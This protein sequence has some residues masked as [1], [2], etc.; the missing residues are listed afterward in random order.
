[1]EDINTRAFELS[2]RIL[3]VTSGLDLP[4]GNWE[5][6]VAGVFLNQANT[7]LSSIMTLLSEN[8]LESAIILCRSLFELAVDAVYIYRDPDKLDKRV[9]Q[10]LDCAGIPRTPEATKELQLEIRENPHPELDEII[11]PRRWKTLKA[12]CRD[13]GPDWVKEYDTFYRYASDHTHSGP[14]LFATRLKRLLERQEGSAQQQVRV[15]MTASSFHLRVAG[16]AAETF[17]KHIN[18]ECVMALRIENNR[19]G[20]AMTCIGCG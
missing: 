9:D 10:Y 20:N 4:G 1:M 3:E 14:Y 16:I 19:L 12:M 15:L 7:R 5:K 2:E 11:P 18:R 8:D 6:L 13:L 17:P